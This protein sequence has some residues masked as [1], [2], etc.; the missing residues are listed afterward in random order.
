ME[1][2]A[3]EREHAGGAE[4]VNCSCDQAGVE[5]HEVDEGR[6]GRLARRVYNLGSLQYNQTGI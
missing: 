4:E 1:E 3:N 6:N 5:Q 2:R